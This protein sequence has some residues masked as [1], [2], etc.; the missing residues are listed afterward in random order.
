MAKTP[1]GRVKDEVRE[2]L[3]RYTPAVWW[4]MPIGGMFSMPGIPDIVGVARGKFFAI[5]VKSAKGRPTKMQLA[6]HTLIEDAGGVIA[7]VKPGEVDIEQQVRA[8]L[9]RC[10]ITLLD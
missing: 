4:F 7:I 5:E 10:G 3:K 9:A 6:V 2:E 8:V 1:E